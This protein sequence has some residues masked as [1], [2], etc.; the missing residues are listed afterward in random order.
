M[1]TGIIEEVGRVRAAG[2]D[3]IEITAARVLEGTALGDSIAVNGACLTAARLG[4]GWFAADVMPETLRRTNLGDL[5]PG[6]GVNLER[7]MTLA[8]RVGGHVVQGH[9]DGAG[10]VRSLT[11][12]GDAV[13]VAIAAPSALLRYVVEKGYIAVDGASLTVVDRTD[14]QFRVSLVRYTLEHTIFGQWQ[15]GQRVNLEIDILAKYVERLLAGSVG[16]PP[17]LPGA[18]EGVAQGERL[19]GL[20]GATSGEDGMDTGPNGAAGRSETPREREEAGEWTRV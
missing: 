11:P 12:E 16:T 15:V 18:G 10:T 19:P 14:E 7:S 13:L 17:Y 4:E 2:S 9:V 6:G 1:F 8:Q 3:H 5:R 20:V